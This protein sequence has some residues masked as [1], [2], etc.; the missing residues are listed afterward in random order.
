MLTYRLLSHWHTIQNF[1]PETT[2]WLESAD[3]LWQHKHVWGMLSDVTIQQIESSASSVTQWLVARGELLELAHDGLRF[4]ITSVGGQ[5]LT[6]DIPTAH[7]HTSNGLINNLTGHSH[8]PTPPHDVGELFQKDSHIDKLSP[9]KLMR[10]ASA[11]QEA[12]PILL[13]AIGTQ[14]VAKHHYSAAVVKLEQALS[15]AEQLQR[16]D[17][18]RAVRV[19]LCVCWYAAGR[20][21]DVIEG[22]KRGIVL[23][24]H[25]GDD[26]SEARLRN[27]QGLAYRVLGQYRHALE[28]F[29][30]S[31]QVYN[32]L[33]HL[34][35]SRPLS[36]L[37]SLYDY[38]GQVDR[39]RVYFEKALAHEQ[40]EGL[41]DDAII[42][43]AQLGDSYLISQDNVR[44]C[45]YYQQA[46][47]APAEATN[48]VITASV[49][50]ALAVIELEQGHTH[51]A[52]SSLAQALA[53]LE[54]HPHARYEASASAALGR[55]Y[56]QQGQLEDAHSQ[57]EDAQARA[58]Q[59]DDKRLIVEI[60][61]ILA[62]VYEQQGQLAEALAQHRL[63]ARGRD[64]LLE[65]KRQRY[66]TGLMLEFDVSSEQQ[67][68]QQAELALSVQT[69][70]LERI[71]DG[72]LA[73][74][75]GGTIT[76]VNHIIETM[77]GH[78]K[79]ALIGSRIGEHFP[80]LP[81]FVREAYDD[82]TEQGEVATLEFFFEQHQRWFD[83]RV[84]PSSGG[85]TVYLLDITDRKLQDAALEE[86][87]DAL[88]Q[89]YTERE[90]ILLSITDCF[91]TLDF[92]GR[93]SY[94]NPKFFEYTTNTDALMGSHYREVFAGSCDL[95]ILGAKFE[96]ALSQPQALT[97]EIESDVY[98][99]W[100]EVRM[101][102]SPQGLAVYSLFIDERKALDSEREQLLRDLH[103]A[104]AQTAAKVTQLEY[105][106]NELEAK[107]NVLEQL[108]QQDGLT[109]LLN[110]RTLDS[111][112]IQELS[113]AKRHQTPLC[114]AL[115]DIDNFKQV[116]DKLSHAIGDETLKRIAEL[117]S[118]NTRTEDIVARYGGEEFV[119]VFPETPLTAAAE[120][121][122]KI[123]L[124][125][126][127][128]DWHNIH[129]ALVVTLSI[130]LV[131]CQPSY[132]PTMDSD[133]DYANY[134]AMLSAADKQ[135][136]RA[137]HTGKNK[138]C[139]LTSEEDNFS[140][141]M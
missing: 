6:Q 12:L 42:T 40:R 70:L 10:R 27:T 128:D 5:Q 15:L 130:G 20:Y 95:E 60:H 117:L 133:H 41:L 43:M 92:E 56:Y 111:L 25:V 107:N 54:Q 96:L 82:A 18:E 69:E 4:N 94:A 135:M 115:C 58:Q 93:L 124:L 127:A 34:E 26:L 90:I 36:N 11:L 28:S 97:C 29:V 37:A 118:H 62:D 120:A 113:R 13:I 74:D 112:F 78:A 3:F 81:D 39:A 80:Q 101:Y 88:E 116:N 45:S 68:R 30:L 47:R 24:Q 7:E 105:L 77:T 38:L 52:E 79:E 91:Y 72:F 76:Y 121:C 136:Y 19:P 31:H 138:L 99:R 53:L 85:T 75:P 33:L 66:V 126:E 119:L 104:Q 14:Q 48:P 106:H 44:A 67:A 84:Y 22:A 73:I 109:K 114:I 129:P 8:T 87:R 64:E 59:I 51:Q 102:P 32:Q 1:E 61:E 17:L 57:L 63:Y 49:Y 137:K 103:D 131:S 35:L 140:D 83:M 100:L 50:T 123:R 2:R 110:R 98:G 55:L 23:A 9:D 16:D 89:A 86:V 141:D 139:Y 108:S 65:Q 125:V 132:D 46:L 122:E 21:A 134:S 71:T